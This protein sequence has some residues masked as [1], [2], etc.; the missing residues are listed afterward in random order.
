MAGKAR[1]LTTPAHPS[2]APVPLLPLGVDFCV[3][4]PA[5]PGASKGAREAA[6]LGTGNVVPP[7]T[8]RPPTPGGQ[9]PGPPCGPWGLPSSPPPPQAHH[10]WV[11][12]LVYPAQGVWPWQPLTG[13]CRPSSP[14]ATGVCPVATGNCLCRKL[15]P[16][17]S[18]MLIDGQK[19]DIF[20]SS[21]ATLGQGPSPPLEPCRPPATLPNSR[22]RPAPAHPLVKR[23]S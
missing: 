15:S 4:G 12:D 2:T 1:I 6:V 17:R 19:C 7:E 23:G 14:G 5:E 18:L 8:L 20:W 10:Q 13:C 16:Y 22:P 9:R 3:P 11:P 21:A